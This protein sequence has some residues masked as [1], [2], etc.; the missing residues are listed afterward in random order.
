MKIDVYVIDTSSFI[1][2]KPED[3]PPDIYATQWTNMGR[4]VKEHRLISSKIVFGELE[5]KNDNIC[6]WANQNKTM[7]KEITP[8]QTELV[9]QII[10]T[11]DFA[12][13][14]DASA[15]GG[16]SDP[17]IIAM[18]LEEEEQTTLDSLER[19][20]IVVTEETLRGNRI[21]IPFVCN[22]YGIEYINIFD[23][24]RREKWVW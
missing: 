23:L 17:F 11:D 7:F 15:K 4:L 19:K 9:K 18:A 21:R 3:Y 8:Q 22:H 5:E 2:I 1:R 13:L 6:I 12:A 10:N 14:F 24:F 20:K 16:Q